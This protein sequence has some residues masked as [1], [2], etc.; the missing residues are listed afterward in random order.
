MASLRATSAR[1][2]A[3]AAS[4]LR[5]LLGRSF[6]RVNGR[7]SPSSTRNRTYSLW[8]LATWRA[9]R[10][11]PSWVISPWRM[12]VSAASTAGAARAAEFHGYS[13]TLSSPNSA[14][15]ETIQP[16]HHPAFPGGTLRAF[17]AV[18][19]EPVPVLGTADQGAGVAADGTVEPDR[20]LLAV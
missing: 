1:Q 12:A 18:D 5:G 17:P 4:I 11:S 16:R 9:R 14:A 15:H 13:V 3:T 10:L 20:D 19:H 2:L 8:A 6:W 7:R